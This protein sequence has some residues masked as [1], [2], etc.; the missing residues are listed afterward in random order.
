MC[1]QV[2]EKGNVHSCIH[3]LHSEEV[4]LYFDINEVERW[5]DHTCKLL[6]QNMHWQFYSN[7]M[8][9]QVRGDHN[10]RLRWEV[11]LLLPVFKY[12][13]GWSD[14]FFF[15]RPVKCLQLNKHIFVSRTRNKNLRCSYFASFLC[16]GKVD[17]CFEIVH[18]VNTS[19]LCS[20][21]WAE[22]RLS[23]SR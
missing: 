2:A 18:H 23:A 3:P 19:D 21:L 17:E 1:V 11:T 15:S 12:L 10:M 16:F 20:P 8:Q 22:E 6:Q 7:M 9:T 5:T 4:A 14:C 13:Y